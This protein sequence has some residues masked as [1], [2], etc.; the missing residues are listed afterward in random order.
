MNL[1]SYVLVVDCSDRDDLLTRRQFVWPIQRN[2]HGLT[3]SVHLSKFSK[4]SL[5]G[6]D[7]I[8]FSGCTLKDNAFVLR[9]KKLG[10]L[11]DAGVPMLG[12]CAG[13]E[14]LGIVFG[15]KLERLK[16]PIIGMETVKIDGKKTPGLHFEEGVFSA[17]HLNGNVVSLPNGFIGVGH[18]KR[19]KNEIMVHL[20]LKVVGFQFHPEYTH[21]KFIQSFVRWANTKN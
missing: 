17:Y 5:K 12:I 15:G 7:A 10:W 18:S 9:A 3:S 8:I 16:F 21:G 19:I 4:S 2:I 11:K 6:F 20:G 13:H 14:L 1:H